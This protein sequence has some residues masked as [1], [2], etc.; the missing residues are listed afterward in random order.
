MSI[1][2]VGMDWN[3]TT[4]PRWEAG[5]EAGYDDGVDSGVQA[6]FEDGID[7]GAKHGYEQALIDVIRE[8]ERTF[9]MDAASRR[10]VATVLRRVAAMN[11]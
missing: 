11:A 5:Y 9:P 1:A 3:D 8:T 2:E 4:D 6:G 10:L 7:E